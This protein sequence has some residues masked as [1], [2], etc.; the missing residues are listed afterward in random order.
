MCHQPG[1]ADTA[2]SLDDH[3]PDA[4]AGHLGQR[5][6]QNREL[7]RPPGQSSPW[8]SVGGGNRR[9]G[10]V[11]AVCR[12]GNDKAW[13]GLAL[14]YRFVDRVGRRRRVDPKVLPK[15]LAGA[16]ECR[17]RGTRLP[18]VRQCRH[19]DLERALVVRIRRDDRLAHLAGTR[20]VADRQRS[21]RPSAPYFDA[22]L[23]DGGPL[24]V[25]PRRIRLIG[26]QLA[27]H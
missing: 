21:P 20:K 4:P 14:E 10:L 7:R 26:Q 25:G 22:Q 16:G 19:E 13:Y 17:Q 23:D 27:T 6:V 15:A 2:V 5:R 24:L 11:T 18:A 1:L 12:H 3:E 9:H 8:R